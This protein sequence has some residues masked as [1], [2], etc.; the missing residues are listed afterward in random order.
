MTMQECLRCGV[1]NTDLASGCEEC[2]FDFQN[3]ASELLSATFWDRFKAFW[4]DLLVLSIPALLLDLMGFHNQK[5]VAF[6]GAFWPIF[7]LY[8]AV[9]ESSV[10]QATLGKRIVGLR[11]TDSTGARVSF[12]RAAGRNLG[13]LLSSFFVIGYL[14][15]FFSRRR[16]T[17]H[18]LMSSCLV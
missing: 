9:M 2:L 8:F 18:D 13:R 17:L 7:I 10:W 6:L 11:V 5:S 16:Q 4:L 3:P 15:V 1:I 12:R 14:F